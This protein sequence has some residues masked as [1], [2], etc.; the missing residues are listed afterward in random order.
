[1]SLAISQQRK[2]YV[3]L[4][5]IIMDADNLK[6]TGGI[7]PKLRGSADWLKTSRNLVC[8]YCW[9]LARLPGWK[10]REIVLYLRLGK[11]TLRERLISVDEDIIVTKGEAALRKLFRPTQPAGI[12]EFVSVMGS[13]EYSNCMSSSSPVRIPN[14]VEIV[15]EMIGERVELAISISLYLTVTDVEN[16]QEYHYLS[17]LRLSRHLSR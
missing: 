17:C 11:L 9:A 2:T 15:K 1:M 6:A 16:L 5:A 13:G 4:F 3:T 10:G 7:R 12:G 8:S 14:I